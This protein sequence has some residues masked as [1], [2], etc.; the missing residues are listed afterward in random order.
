VRSRFRR[1]DVPHNREQQETTDPK[2]TSGRSAVDARQRLASV[3]IR[4][5]GT[6]IEGVVWTAHFAQRTYDSN[7]HTL[8]A[9]YVGS[10]LCPPGPLLRSGGA[11]RGGW[12]LGRRAMELQHRARRR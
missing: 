2:Q 3:V 12:L 6:L 11:G 9:V 1:Q 7:P 4:S 8:P 10:Q 5:F